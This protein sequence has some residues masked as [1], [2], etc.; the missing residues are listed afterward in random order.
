MKSE[1]L[2]KSFKLFESLTSHQFESLISN[3][4][5]IS[6]HK[7]VYLKRSDIYYYFLLEGKL[8]VCE[9]NPEGDQVI[10]YILSPGTF[11]NDV[12]DCSPG[13]EDF[14][15]A[16]GMA[17]KV[18]AIPKIELNDSLSKNISFAK[19]IGLLALKKCNLIEHQLRT[20]ILKDTK[21]RLIRLISNMAKTDGIHQNNKCIVHNY[22]T[23][24][25]IASL[26]GAT[27][28]TVTKYFGELKASG[29][30]DYNRHQIQVLSPKLLSA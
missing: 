15:M 28:V 23:H 5:F 25:E 18:V 19:E 20:L 11:F 26:I 3:S 21:Q 4:K 16:T 10:K 13:D 22:L 14:A 8:K 2:F 17:P 24:R 6:I 27:R 29:D 30:L 7:D 9:F 12:L 1:E